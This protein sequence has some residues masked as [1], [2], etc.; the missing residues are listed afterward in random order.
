MFG[1]ELFVVLMVLAV[2]ALGPLFRLVDLLRREDY[3]VVGNSRVLWALIVLFIPFA[4][5]F[6]FALGRR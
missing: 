1:F 4:W 5:I 6:H 2:L 3:E